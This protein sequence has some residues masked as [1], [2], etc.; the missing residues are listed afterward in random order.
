MDMVFPG[1]TVQ[2]IY[3]EQYLGLT[4]GRTD[5]LQTYNSQPVSVLLIRVQNYKELYTTLHPNPSFVGGVSLFCDHMINYE[6]KKKKRH[7]SDF[8]YLLF[9]Y[10]WK[11]KCYI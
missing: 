6:K 1:H 2:E 5:E 11:V 3:S 7:A 8:F 4:E 9:F 10:F